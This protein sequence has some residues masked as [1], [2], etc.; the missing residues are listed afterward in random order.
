M[1]GPRKQLCVVVAARRPDRVREALRAAVGLSL[2][3]DAVRV[4][5]ATAVDDA[6]PA[7]RRALGTLRA[8]GHTVTRTSDDPAAAARDADAV[9]VWT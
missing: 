1:T 7:V 9:E 3:G 6:D 2:R 4:V 5:L 8:L